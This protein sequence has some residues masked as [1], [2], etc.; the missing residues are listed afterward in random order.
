MKV[1]RP[2]K[3]LKERAMK[4]LFELRFED[5]LV[6][7]KASL[8]KTSGVKIYEKVLERIGRLKLKYSSSHS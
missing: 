3:A 1:T 5:G 7:I 6:C 2:A 4:T 8:T